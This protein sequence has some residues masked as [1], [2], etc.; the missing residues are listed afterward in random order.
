M[1]KRASKTAHGSRS[2]EPTYGGYGRRSQGKSSWAGITEADA[3]RANPYWLRTLAQQLFYQRCNKVQMAAAQQAGAPVNASFKPRV[4]PQLSPCYAAYPHN[5]IAARAAFGLTAFLEYQSHLGQNVLEAHLQ[6]FLIDVSVAISAGLDQAVWA[7]T[8]RLVART[9]QT[10][11]LL[12]GLSRAPSLACVE[13]YRLFA[14]SQQ[15]ARFDTLLEIIEAVVLYGDVLADWT[16]Q[17]L[18]PTTRKILHDLSTV[19]EPYFARLQAEKPHLFIPLG[20]EWVRVLCATLQKYLPLAAP[21]QTAPAPTAP[22]SAAHAAPQTLDERLSVRSRDQPPRDATA[23]LDPLNKPRPPLIDP[24]SDE[25][26][27]GMLLSVSASGEAAPSGAVADAI[28]EFSKACAGAS[29]QRTNFEDLR[30]DLVVQKVRSGSFAP[31][32]IQGTPTEGHEVTV[33]LNGDVTAGGELFDRPI[34]LSC[35]FLAYEQLLAQARPATEALRRALYP[36]IEESPVT[37]R[38]RPSGTLDPTRLAYADFSSAVF[39]RTCV[40]ERADRR[41]KPVLLIA[42]DGSGSL[43]A[44]QMSMLKVLATAWL[45]S[46]VK[47]QVQVLAALY[48]SGDV[49]KNLTGPLVQWIYHPHKTQATSR[50]DAARTLVSLPKSGT[51]CQSDALSIAFLLEEARRLARGRMVY[52]ILLTDTAWNVS[53]HIGKTGKEEMLDLLTE[54][55]G[56]SAGRLHVTLVALGPSQTT[57]GFEEVVD[58]VIHVSQQELTDFVAVAQKIAVYVGATMKERQRLVGDR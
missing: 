25:Q 41:G 51:G 1:R 16:R 32:P 9:V 31:G 47:T 48:H 22:P 14:A 36:N 57:T 53:F 58:K 23:P 44:Q 50:R 4:K 46:T 39:R 7:K 17:A 33:R 3:F 45:N 11:L 29:G 19:C 8:K 5:L 15:T 37:E 40:L 54:A 28:A 2:P 34:E 55:I 43:S 24:P 56:E 42:C 21:A 18:H 10:R 52:L 26:L 38:Y 20:V 13:L 35:D 49:R 12:E 27:A 30:S 6:P